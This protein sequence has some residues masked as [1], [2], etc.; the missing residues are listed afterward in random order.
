MIYR[1][2]YNMFDRLLMLSKN[3]SSF[4]FGARSTGKTTY[5]QKYF[6]PETTYIID[7]LDIETE[8]RLSRQPSL[9]KNI[10]DQLDSRYTHVIIDEI[11]KVPRLLDV[12]HQ[13][14]QKN[15]NRFFFIL[16]GSSAKKLKAGGSDLLAGRAFLYNMFPLTYL[17]LGESFDISTYLHYGGLPGIYN[18]PDNS[19]KERYLKSYGLMYLKEEVWNEHLIRKLNPFR[20]FLELAALANGEIINYKKISSQIKVDAKTVQSYYEIL[21]DT[22]LGF[23]LNAYNTS[24]RKQLISSPKFF[25]IDT[26]IKRA[27][28]NTLKVPLIPGTFAYG[29]AFEH[30]VI[31]Q[32]FY[33]NHYF[34]SD[35]K[36]YYLKTKDGAE[37]DLIIKKPDSSL[38]CIEI[39]STD[40]STTANTRNLM[41]LAK[42]LNCQDQF[43][44]SQD[45]ITRKNGTIIYMHWKDGIELIFNKHPEMP[46]KL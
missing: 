35:Y 11:Q 18:L 33:L 39:K 43:C 16:T 32:I 21:A 42:D 1:I 22:L 3:Y 44:F 38:I 13:Y 40:D 8:D 46:R 45:P 24:I 20:S 34:E 26:G 6:S 23:T 14:I 28:D 15:E 2:L 19:D 41:N 17:E 12:I 25:F 30:F 10:L 9:L 4:L 37:I 29:K 5:L 31:T 7:L 27:L 36:L